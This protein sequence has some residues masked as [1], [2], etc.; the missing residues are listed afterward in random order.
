MLAVMPDCA[1][2]A[3]PTAPC[4]VALL[5]IAVFVIFARGNWL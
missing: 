4:R 1:A 5:S 2:A 3:A